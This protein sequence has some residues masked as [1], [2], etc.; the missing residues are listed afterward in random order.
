M[1]EVKIPKKS[2]QKNKINNERKI[3]TIIRQNKNTTR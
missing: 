3:T 1:V 2:Y